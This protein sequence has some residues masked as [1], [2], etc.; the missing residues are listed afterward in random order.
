M[1]YSESFI[2]SGVVYE[3]TCKCCGG[4]KH[5]VKGVI[6]YGYFFLESLPFCP[7]GRRVQ[8]TC[9]D[10]GHVANTS[11]LTENLNKRLLASSFH[12]FQY[13]IRFAG[14]FLL[15]YIMFSWWQSHQDEKRLMAKLIAEPQINDF[16]LF[17]VRML[18]GEKRPN[19]K[20]Q[21]AKVVDITGDTI[22]LSF[23]S[24]YYK[25]QASF[26]DAI[27][28]G[29]VRVPSYF[30]KNHTLFS[31]AKLKQMYQQQAIVIV[32]R[33]DQN[34]L[35]GNFVINH[36]GYRVGST[37]FPGERQFASGLAFEQAHYLENY[38]QQA[39]AKFVEAAEL[40]F[41]L[42]QIKLAEYYLASDVVSTDFYQALYWLEQASLQ[43]HKRAINKYGI[44]CQQTTGCDVNSFYQRLID[45][46]VN[47]TVN[48]NGEREVK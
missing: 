20:Y 17:D 31:L 21:I 42:A 45:A 16:M 2:D 12:L 9:A 1:E 8:L 33:P 24:F 5:F 34:M 38:K 6:K 3:H 13:L 26:R 22:S 25:F 47:L 35:Y 39:F 29:Q 32:A 44:I 19:E 48:I 28:N 15:T 11:E 27:A 14:T 43:S 40:G 46:G 7:V 10:C 41:A 18:P 4:E 23:G 30:S 36:T 37:Y